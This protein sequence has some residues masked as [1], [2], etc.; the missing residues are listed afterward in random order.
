MV[1]E[2]AYHHEYFANFLS[3]QQDAIMEP[4]ETSSVIPTHSN[5]Q[6]DVA[7]VGMACRT[8]GGVKSP[9]D[10]WKLLLGREC[11]S[12]EIPKHR[13]DAWKRRDVR[14]TGVLKDTISKGYF[15]NNLEMFDAA[16]FGISPKEAEQMD[17]H[18]R[19]GLELTA[20][21]LENAGF[22]TQRLSGSDTAV[23]MGVD[24]DDFSRLVLEDLPNIE[25]WMGVGTAP[26]GLPN[27]ISYHWNL[28]GPSAAVDAACA[29]S[30]VAVH[31]GRQS[32]LA[33]ESKIA[34]VGG[35]QVDIA[36]ALFMVSNPKVP[37]LPSAVIN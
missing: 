13:W 3:Y 9:E 15:I 29:S 26:H 1:N 22:D 31:L 35:V 18:Q 32:I 24:S 6:D 21:A 17:P 8:A 14:N 10:L 7:I 2:S 37:S 36:P 33:G 11:A 19:M 23:Y 25:P 27:R 12:G 4:A 20:E 30:L 16:S 28:H 5:P 34:I